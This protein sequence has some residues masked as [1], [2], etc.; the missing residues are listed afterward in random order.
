MWGAEPWKKWRRQQGLDGSCFV[1]QRDRHDRVQPASRY[2]EQLH[3]GQHCNTNWYEGNAGLLGLPHIIPTF[4]HHAPALLGFDEAIDEY[5]NSK[6]GTGGHAEACIQASLNILSLYGNRVPYNICRNYEWLVCSALGKL[7]GQGSKT[8]I[9]SEAPSALDFTRSPR[10]GHCSGWSP[11]DCQGQNGYATDSI[12]FLEVC[13]YSQICANGHELFELKVGQPWQ[14]EFD[15][16]AFWEL[17]RILME[18][19]G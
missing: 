11:I 4:A 1:W 3:S 18:P 7:P 2:F 6:G 17:P 8:I 12:F 13:L 9:F 15:D 5:C 16:E 10:L 14:C 19:P